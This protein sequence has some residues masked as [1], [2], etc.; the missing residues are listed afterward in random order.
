[1]WKWTALSI[2]RG[3]LALRRFREPG[4]NG[5]LRTTGASLG[6]NGRWCA[7]VW[8]SL[9]MISVPPV[10]GPARA[11]REISGLVGARN[12]A[13][14]AFVPGASAPPR[15]LAPVG[16]P[17]GCAHESCRHR[18]VGLAVDILRSLAVPPVLAG[19]LGGQNGDG[20]PVHLLALGL[21]HRRQQD[22]AVLA[23]PQGRRSLRAGFLVGP[24]ARGALYLA[25]RQTRPFDRGAVRRRHARMEAKL[26]GPCPLY[27]RAAYAH[28]K[29]DGC[30]HR[31]RGRTYGAPAS[32]A[33]HGRFGRPLYRAIR[34]GL[35]YPDLFPYHRGVEKHLAGGGRARHCRSFV[36]DR[37]RPCCRHSGDD[38]LQ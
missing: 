18:A 21:G 7:L 24:V 28:R 16:S 34:H 38:F 4:V 35:G 8:T 22:E 29:S 19:P 25:C 3:C 36:R 31:P 1:M 5:A 37:N 9:A 10:A 11:P 13:A 14:L 2:W 15:S 27:R 12:A 30:R 23:H 33:G 20:R 6:R 17:K 32:G 26:R